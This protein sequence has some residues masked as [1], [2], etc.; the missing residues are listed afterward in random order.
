MGYRMPM[1]GLQQ[2][3]IPLTETKIDELRQPFGTRW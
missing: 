3:F 2:G 1:R